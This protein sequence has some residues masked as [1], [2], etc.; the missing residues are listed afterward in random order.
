MRDRRL[1][2]NPKPCFNGLDD[3]KWK[4]RESRPAARHPRRTQP[5]RGRRPDRQT[6][7]NAGA[8]TRNP[9]TARSVWSAAGVYRRYRQDFK[10]AKAV[11]AIKAS[12]SSILYPPCSLRFAAHPA[13]DGDSRQALNHENYQTNPNVKFD[14]TNK[15]GPIPCVWTP[16]GWKNEPKPLARSSAFR[17]LRLNRP[18]P[19]AQSPKPRLIQ[20]KSNRIKPNQTKNLARLATVTARPRRRARTC[21]GHSPPPH[22]MNPSCGTTPNAT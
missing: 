7:P 17:R 1:F 8:T 6:T 2:L 13:D 12:P 18:A 22:R 16:V 11:A 20:T 14:F 19:G 5:P 10:V 21:N 3:Q 15:S 9:R 4:N